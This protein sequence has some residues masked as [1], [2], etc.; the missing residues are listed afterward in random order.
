VVVQMVVHKVAQMVIIVDKGGTV[1]QMDAIRMMNLSVQQVGE[2]LVVVTMM[3][4]QMGQETSLGHAHQ[5]QDA[6]E[7]LW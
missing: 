4:I 3:A 1:S 2:I 7:E 5:S 6:H